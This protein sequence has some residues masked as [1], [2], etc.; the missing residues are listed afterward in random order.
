M[1]HPSKKLPFSCPICGRKKDYLLTELLEGAA[2]TCPFCKLTLTLHG[3][4]WEDVRK[5]IQ[6]LKDDGK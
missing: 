3:H 4:M 1:K 6:K 2:L 5:E